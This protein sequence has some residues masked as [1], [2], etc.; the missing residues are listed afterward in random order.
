MEIRREKPQTSN[1]LINILMAY[2]YIYIYI[3]ISSN[4]RFAEAFSNT[5]RHLFLLF[6]L[7]IV[8]EVVLPAFL[9]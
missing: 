6:L 3:Y 7:S 4:E 5:K 9:V 8:F 2:I 1:K